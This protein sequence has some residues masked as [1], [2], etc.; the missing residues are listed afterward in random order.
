MQQENT[1]ML[2]ITKVLAV[3]K[4]FPELDQATFLKDKSC[5]AF[6]FLPR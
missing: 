1:P 6:N 2:N 5:S 3:T 4:T